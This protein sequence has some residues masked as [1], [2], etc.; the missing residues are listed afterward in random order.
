MS[1][2]L[3]LILEG[4][5][6]QVTDFDPQQYQAR[7]ALD[8]KLNEH[9]SIVPLGYVYT[10]NYKYGKQPA[11]FANNEHRIW[12]QVFYKH[13]IG[14]VKMDHRVRL[15]ERFLEKHVSAPDGRVINEEY[16]VNQ[17][18]LRYRL[19]ARVPLNKPAIEPG[20][21]FVSA[22]DEIFVSWGDF[23]TYHE[24]DQNRIFA[25]LGYQFDKNFTLQSGFLYQM[26]VKAN[27][28]KQE[29]NLGFQIQLTYNVDCTRSNP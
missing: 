22:Y 26:I 24:P 25:G 6:R 19:M 21:Y 10:W 5:F 27:G 16:S 18:R 7:T 9:F 17:T 2:R 12:Q 4:Q 20:S 29:N 28:A 15:E 23:V 1:K 3:S 13:N 8:I 11:L 14:R